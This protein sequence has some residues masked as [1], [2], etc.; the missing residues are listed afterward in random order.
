MIGFKHLKHQSVLAVEVIILV[1]LQ[2]V[3][4][5]YFTTKWQLVWLRNV[6][7]SKNHTWGMILIIIHHAV[8][9]TFLSY[10]SPI[11]CII[12]FL[13]YKCASRISHGWQCRFHR[14]YQMNLL[15]DCKE[16]LS[17]MYMTGNLWHLLTKLIVTCDWW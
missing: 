16:I 17:G 14:R 2:N 7:K 1:G 15:C 12:S 11:H 4:T 5:V 9:N 10:L 8:S 6:R 13:F 3:F